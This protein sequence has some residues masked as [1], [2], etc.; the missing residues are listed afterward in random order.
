MAVFAFPIIIGPEAL[1]EWTFEDKGAYNLARKKEH[2]FVST[3]QEILS[4]Q[5]GGPIAFDNRLIGVKTESKLDE[6][7]EMKLPIGNNEGL[8]WL[9]ESI[10]KWFEEKG[11]KSA[12]QVSRSSFSHLMEHS[13]ISGI[14]LPI[15]FS[16]S[17]NCN[18][19][20]DSISI[21]SSIKVKKE[22][23]LW[24][25]QILPWHEKKASAS[26]KI[27]K[28]YAKNFIDVIDFSIEKGVAVEIL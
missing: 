28:Y 12:E 13:P 7:N 2:K 3:L 17:F 22:L 1:L 21:G 15:D 5:L 14:F 25:T 23:D 9:K 27:Y 19:R 8:I 10:K 24:L 4:A 18:L 20:G 6:F 26:G 11:G 16:R